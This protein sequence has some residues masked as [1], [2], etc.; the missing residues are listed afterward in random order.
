M[1]VRTSVFRPATTSRPLVGCQVWSVCVGQLPPSPPDDGGRPTPVTSP[2]SVRSQRYIHA[3]KQRLRLVGKITGQVVRDSSASLSRHIGGG[4]FGR[5]DTHEWHGTPAEQGNCL[6]GDQV[7]SRSGQ[8][9]VST[10]V[11]DA[12]SGRANRDTL[13]RLLTV[14]NVL[15]GTS[16]NKREHQ[17]Q[18]C[19]KMSLATY[20]ETSL[21]NNSE[22]S[23]YER[24][25]R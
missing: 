21:L 12:V 6:V 22:V 14:S 7:F 25:D 3:A 11:A 20:E 13:S 4:V 10:A 5:Q 16:W 19:I 8:F 24:D 1:S 2:T 15:T 9:L 18:R 23:L 17:E